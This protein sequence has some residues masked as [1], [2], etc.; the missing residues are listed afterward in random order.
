MVD[1][2]IAMLR[3]WSRLIRMKQVLRKQAADWSDLAK[4]Q[5][6]IPVQIFRNQ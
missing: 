1:F 4:Y 6:D 3:Q 2:A 5:N